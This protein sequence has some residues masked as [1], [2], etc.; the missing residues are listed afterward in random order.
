[1]IESAGGFFKGLADSVGLIFFAFFGGVIRTIY[2][3]RSRN[4]R[5][6]FVS[7]MISVPLGVLAGMIGEDMGLSPAV[8][9]GLAV[10]VGIISHDMIEAVFWTVDKVKMNR[11]SIFGL[12][13]KRL[14]GKDD[15]EQV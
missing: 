7:I 10:L 1:M 12:L 15:N 13:L 4:L 11:E 9:M 14:A 8:D 3:P 5:A 6:Y 2:R